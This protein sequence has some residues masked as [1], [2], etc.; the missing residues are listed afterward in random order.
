[1]AQ[2]FHAELDAY[3]ARHAGNPI[4]EKRLH[5][6]L[7][8]NP[9]FERPKDLIL[10]EELEQRI[11]YISKILHKQRI[12]RQVPAWEFAA[13]QF[14]ALM[15]VPLSKLATL[16]SLP[17]SAMK[18]FLNELEPMVKRFLQNSRD[19]G[20]KSSQAS[21][22]APSATSQKG[23]RTKM[24]VSTCKISDK[25]RCVITGSSDPQACHIIPFTWNN[26]I[27]ARADAQRYEEAIDTLIIPDDRGSQI[28]SNDVK[29]SDKA[30]NMISLSPLL[31]SWW[32]RGY[33][34]LKWLGYDILTENENQDPKVNLLS[35]IRHV[36][37][38]ERLPDQECEDNCEHCTIIHHVQAYRIRQHYTIESG[39]IIRVVRDKTDIDNFR[40]MI[41]IQWAMICIAAMS[42]AAQVP[43]ALRGE[44]DDEPDPTE[45]INKWLI[46]VQSVPTLSIDTPPSEVDETDDLEWDCK[47]NII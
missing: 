18:R 41:D 35:M 22:S 25:Q 11:S 7:Q 13:I 23:S 31:H 28:L 3:L 10:T 5:E 15:T 1:M 30:W 40:L 44:D 8:S 20:V 36:Y 34:G 47:E 17:G 29:A 14:S 16:V 21:R 2:P 4:I 33:F 42:G 6:L 46:G 45:V 12:S 37:G 26:T 19:S 9:E 39:H 27:Q 24:E 43:E 32:A 38:G